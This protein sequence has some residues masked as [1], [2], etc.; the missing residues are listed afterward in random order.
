MTLEV[1]SGRMA[2]RDRK[3]KEKVLSLGISPLLLNPT[4]EQRC[5]LWLHVRALVE[6]FRGTNKY[7]SPDLS[8]PPQ[9]A[10]MGRA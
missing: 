5:E 4:V 9:E 10:R 3:G 8:G 2:L 1:A 7:L 6:L